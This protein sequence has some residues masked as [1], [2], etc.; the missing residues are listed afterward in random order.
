[1]TIVKEEPS[2]AAYNAA[3][4]ALLAAT[5][6]GEGIKFYMGVLLAMVYVALIDG[7]GRDVVAQNMELFHSQLLEMDSMMNRVM[8]DSQRDRVH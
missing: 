2:V 6:K 1:M 3:H 4:E 7:L 5:P 8:P